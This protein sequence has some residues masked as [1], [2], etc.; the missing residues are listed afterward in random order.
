MSEKIVDTTKLKVS[1]DISVDREEKFISSVNTAL[2]ASFTR[3]HEAFS[4]L[5]ERLI[6]GVGGVTLLATS[7]A[8]VDEWIKD[9]ELIS[10]LY[11]AIDAKD[12]FCCHYSAIEENVKCPP[13]HNCQLCNDVHLG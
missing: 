11:Q 10:H 13:L 1:I 6:S 12:A 4:A 5:A 8:Y 3:T 2:G 9:R 7:T